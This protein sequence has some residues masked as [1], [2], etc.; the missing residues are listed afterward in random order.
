MKLGEASVR[1]CACVHVCVSVCLCDCR[2]SITVREKAGGIGK[3]KKKRERKG[4]S[5]CKRGEGGGGGAVG[6]LFSSVFVQRR[7]DGCV[8]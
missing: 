6:G 8:H 5:E 2:E 7:A 1:M 4:G 3:H